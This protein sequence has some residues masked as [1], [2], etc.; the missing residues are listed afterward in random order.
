MVELN[1]LLK[2]PEAESMRVALHP[3]A[4]LT[5]RWAARGVAGP[6]RRC[7]RMPIVGMIPIPYDAIQVCSAP[8]PYDVI[9]TMGCISPWSVPTEAAHRPCLRVACMVSVTGCMCQVG[10]GTCCAKLAMLFSH[11][12][13]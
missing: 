3:F 13:L 11:A 1:Q 4:R 5:K 6:R 9:M 7:N 2:K 12:R 8:Y 10:S